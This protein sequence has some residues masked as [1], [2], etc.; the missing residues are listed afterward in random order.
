MT[1]RQVLVIVEDELSGAVMRRLIASF[2]C[3]LELFRLIRH[4]GYG[5]I[6]ANVPQYR[7]A[8]KAMPHI[9]LTDLDRHECPPSLLMQW[10]A[11]ALPAAVSMHVA[12]HE[13]EAWLLADREGMASLLKLP[14]N[15]VPLKPEAEPDPKQCLINLARRYGPA[16]VKRDLVPEQGSSARIGPGYNAVLGQFVATNW[17]PARA[18]EYSPSLARASVRLRSFMC[19]PNSQGG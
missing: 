2:A 7:S 5:Q 15:K 19:E 4:S 3:H 11:S 12:V 9:I 13:V 14:L 8:S 1:Q 6:K 10:D 17:N 16:R 18:C